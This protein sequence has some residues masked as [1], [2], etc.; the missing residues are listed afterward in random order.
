[1]CCDVEGYPPHEIVQKKFKDAAK[2]SI[3]FW[4]WFFGFF[5]EKKKECQKKKS[6]REKCF[7]KK[8]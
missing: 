4:L 2:K 8:T 5:V 6:G 7:F 1:M 3:V